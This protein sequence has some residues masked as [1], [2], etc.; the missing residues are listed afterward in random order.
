M[1]LCSS[2]RITVKIKQQCSE[3]RQRCVSQIRTHT[4]SRICFFQIFTLEA[5]QNIKTLWLKAGYTISSHPGQKKTTLWETWQSLWS[6][7]YSQSYDVLWD[8]FKDGR[9]SQSCDQRKPAVK[10]SEISDDHLIVQLLLQ[11]TNANSPPA[12]KWCCWCVI[13]TTV[14]LIHVRLRAT[15]QFAFSWCNLANFMSYPSL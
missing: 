7:L 5:V 1:R 8:W 4:T 15:I 11:L 12:K 9:L 13:L 6:W 3:L 10:L 14:R 2:L